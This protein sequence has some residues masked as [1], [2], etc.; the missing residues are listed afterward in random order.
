MLNFGGL[1]WDPIR[2]ICRYIAKID[3]RQIWDYW[4]EITMGD[5]GENGLS[6]GIVNSIQESLSFVKIREMT[7]YSGKQKHP[8]LTMDSVF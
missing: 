3:W 4:M 2:K 7:R 6:M 8:E 1:W 5:L